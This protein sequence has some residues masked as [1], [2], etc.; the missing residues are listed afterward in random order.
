MDSWSSETFFKARKLALSGLKRK[1]PFPASWSIVMEPPWPGSERTGQPGFTCPTRFGLWSLTLCFL[2][3]NLS[4]PQVTWQ[5]VPLLKWR[6]FKS[7]LWSGVV[8]LA[9]KRKAC[10]KLA[11]WVLPISHE[12]VFYQIRSLFQLA[13]LLFTQTASSSAGSQAGSYLPSPTWRCQRWKLGPSACKARDLPL[14]HPCFY[15]QFP[16]CSIWYPKTVSCPGQTLKQQY[17][18]LWSEIINPFPKPEHTS[19]Q[20]LGQAMSIYT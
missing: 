20:N 6:I 7:S 15:G 5:T 3:G 9:F 12:A 8:C 16:S 14:T 17:L 2:N 10:P 11:F 19:S 1:G 4:A 13:Q 18:L